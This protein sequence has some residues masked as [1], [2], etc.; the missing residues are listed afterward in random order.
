MHFTRY[1]EWARLVERVIS[2]GKAV[3]AGVRFPW[4][5]AEAVG[6]GCR[7][8]LDFSTIEAGIIW[9][10]TRSRSYPSHS[11]PAWRHRAHVGC[12]RSH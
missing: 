2:G 3:E 4:V 10:K 7:S 8:A 12:A 1:A 9:T 6:G 5:R 11:I